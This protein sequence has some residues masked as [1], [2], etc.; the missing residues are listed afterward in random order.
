MNA[1]TAAALSVPVLLLLAG[2]GDATGPG[3]ET[4]PAPIEELPRALS[5]S[6]RAVIE[7]SNAF[8]MD[9]L[10][11]VD[12]RDDAADVFLSGL[13]ASMALA[14]TMNGAAGETW[15]AMRETLR[16]ED[17]SEEAIDTSYRD[18]IALLLELDPRVEIGIANATFADDDF[19]VLQTF[20]DRL[21]AYF[22]A[23]A[24]T[25]DFADPAS[26]AVV[27]AWAKE[28]T[29]DRIDQILESWP[30]GAVL[31]LL[32]AL[33]FKADWTEKF[34][35]AETRPRPFTLASGEVVQ[36][37]AM[38]APDGLVRIG[39]DATTRATI[40]ELPYGGRAF[41]MDIVLPPEGTSLDRLVEGLDAET[42]ERWMA[43]LPEEFASGQVQL[44]KIELEYEKVMN[45]ELIGLGMAI[46]FGEGHV[47]PDFSRI[48][49]GAL[50]IG[51]V[52]QKTWV[53][54]DEEGTE[55]AAVTVVVVLDSAAPMNALVVDRP[56]LI[57]IRE[58]LSGTVLFL[59][60]VRDP[61][62]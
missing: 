55:A 37:E 39:H 42:W 9:L 57:A 35:R 52:K 31:A 38:S 27:N 20:L 43:T 13:S 60:L 61:R 32:N 26:I 24:G 46:A 48:G 34:D 33:Y 50:E 18:L 54:V 7:A 2:C 29:H 4:A 19:A 58:R 47:P 14:M 44:P 53:R 21:R 30:A 36:A 62:S 1:A 6:E 10:R 11:A 56:Y 12:A 45:D 15:D 51:L 59:G 17:L 3:P 23:E 25:L 41:V 5:A 16:F 22:D 49:P 28:K 8:S 40:G